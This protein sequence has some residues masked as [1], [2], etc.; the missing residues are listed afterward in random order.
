MNYSG[1]AADGALYPQEFSLGENHF[2]AL[3]PPQPTEHYEH[4]FQDMSP[5]TVI[6]A[7]ETGTSTTAVSLNWIQ[8]LIDNYTSDDVFQTEFLVGVLFTY[9]GD[10]KPEISPEAEAYLRSKGTKH[11]AFK[12]VTSQ[13]H[14]PRPG[15]YL[16]S[17]LS[18][19]PTWKLYEDSHG[20]FLH[21][22]ILG[23]VGYETAPA[24]RALLTFNK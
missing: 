4:E 12:Q 8:S 9:G 10:K 21:T 7:S 6:F 22:L 24:P 2:L 17:N 15:P 19:R 18:L 20:A 3:W 16:Y 13:D 14:R 1:L 5:V 11:I 23:P